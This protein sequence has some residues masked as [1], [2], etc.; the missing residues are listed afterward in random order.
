[1]RVLLDESLPR[2]LATH[3]VGH[4]TLDVYAQGWS[5][6]KNGELLRLAAAEFDAFVT[7]DRNLRHQQ[8]PTGL[9]L[10]ILVVVARTNRLADLAPLVPKLLETLESAKPGKIIEV[11]GT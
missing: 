6:T 1:M 7:A 10:R 8:N 2:Q 4:E 3:L 9:D 11:T 5:G